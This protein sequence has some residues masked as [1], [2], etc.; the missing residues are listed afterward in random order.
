MDTFVIH[1]IL[2]RCFTEPAERPEKLRI[3]VPFINTMKTF[4]FEQFLGMSFNVMKKI[5]TR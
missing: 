3:V 2:S 4:R 1:S 5:V